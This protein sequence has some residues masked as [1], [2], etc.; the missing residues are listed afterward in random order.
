MSI[1]G[2][3]GSLGCYDLFQVLE[4]GM[5]GVGCGDVTDINE[6]MKNSEQ[7]MHRIYSRLTPE[8]H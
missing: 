8:S 5:E 7:H 3:R 4:E 2:H 1:P 6:S